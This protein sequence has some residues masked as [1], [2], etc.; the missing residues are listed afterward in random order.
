MKDKVVVE[1]E[2]DKEMLQLILEIANELGIDPD[3]VI[4]N[5]IH[6]YIG[7]NIHYIIK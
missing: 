4:R 2:L 5:A 1:I 3:D 6:I 7:K